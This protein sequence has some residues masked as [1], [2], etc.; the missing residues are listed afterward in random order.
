MIVVLDTNV[1]IQALNR[2]HY[3]A[4]ILEDWYAGRF[5]PTSFSSIAR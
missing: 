5:R 3:F 4:I 1:V 2:N